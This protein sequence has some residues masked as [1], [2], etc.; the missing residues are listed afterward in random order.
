MYEVDRI[1]AIIK[2]TEKV[3]GWLHQNIEETAELTLSDIRS[4]STALLLPLF[5]EPDE[6]MEFIQESYLDIFENELASWEIVEESWP[7]VRSFET[8]L[9]WF[10][11][12]FHS[13]VYDMTDDAGEMDIHEKS[14]TTLQ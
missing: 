11:V 14:E 1:V 12:E 2:P 9:K 13:V 10:D 5:D 6:A 7:T 3:L 4:D 8:F